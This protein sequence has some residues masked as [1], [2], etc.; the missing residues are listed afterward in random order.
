MKSLGLTARDLFNSRNGEKLKD[1]VGVVGTLLGCGIEERDD[2]KICIVKI[3][4]II[5]AGTSSTIYE[6]CKMLIENF[7]EEI[8]ERAVK[9]SIGS[10]VSKGGRTFLNINL[11]E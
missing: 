1:S 7:E 2:K 8:K 11:E 6:D 10:R 4:D 5:Y 9:V 3:D